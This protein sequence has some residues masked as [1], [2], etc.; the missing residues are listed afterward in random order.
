MKKRIIIF[1]LV[2]LAIAL[3]Y[4]ATPI[5]ETNVS[6]NLQESTMDAFI[7]YEHDFYALNKESLISKRHT[8]N[9]LDDNILIQRENRVNL[10]LNFEHSAYDLNQSVNSLLKRYPYLKNDVN[11]FH[12]WQQQ[13]ESHLLRGSYVRYFQGSLIFHQLQMMEKINN[14][15]SAHDYIIT[16]GLA[17]T[18]NQLTKLSIQQQCNILKKFGKT[19]STNLLREQVAILAT[20]P[21]ECKY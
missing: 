14:K 16:T 1:A 12:Q 19:D 7:N 11:Q 10:L 3:I 2:F 17:G 4:L 13:A 6:I 15:N 5:P 9:K 8:P 21:P 18:K 20:N